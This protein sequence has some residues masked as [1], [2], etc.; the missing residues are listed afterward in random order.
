MVS[1]LAKKETSPYIP[2]ISGSKD[3]SNFDADVTNESLK[4]SILPEESINRILDKKD[5]FQGFGPIMKTDN[6]GIRKL[7]RSGSASSDND[8]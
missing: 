1:L 3:L 5:A 2:P 7:K 4:E 8:W 6:I